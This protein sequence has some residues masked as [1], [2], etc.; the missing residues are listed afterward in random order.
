MEKGK[1]PF[2]F[3]IISS[4]NQFIIHSTVSICNGIYEYSQTADRS[5]TKYHTN[6]HRQFTLEHR[7]MKSV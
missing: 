5:P 6:D 1:S 7:C 4:N 3:F 2:S